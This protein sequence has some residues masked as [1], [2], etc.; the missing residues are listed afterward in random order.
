MKFDPESSALVSVTPWTGILGVPE[1][2]LTKNKPASSKV[3]NVEVLDRHIFS[4]LTQVREISWL[5][6]Q[7]QR[8]TSPQLVGNIRAAEFKR[9]LTTGRF[10]SF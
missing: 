2:V 5:A 10:F 6:V 8:R 3:R 4:T 1:L 9:R 7:L